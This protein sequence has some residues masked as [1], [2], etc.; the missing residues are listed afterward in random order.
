MSTDTFFS[1]VIKPHPAFTS[2]ARCNNMMLLE[3]VMRSRVECILATMAAAG[4]AM[5]VWETFRST[6]RQEAL[7]KAGKTKL[8]AVGV[9]HYGLAADLVF[10]DG[11]DPSWRGDWELYG[12]AAEEQGLV[13]GGSWATF[14]DCPHVQRIGVGQQAA[15]F[16]GTYYPES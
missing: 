5:Q 3:P 11:M 16:A 10:W 15:L 6:V 2:P 1:R 9:H 12:R 14:H 8:R 4:H 13:W 7:Y